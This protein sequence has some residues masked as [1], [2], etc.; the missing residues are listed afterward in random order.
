M[1]QQRESAYIRFPTIHEDRVVFSAEDDLWLVSAEGGVARRLTAGL[2]RSI[3]P[4]FTPDGQSL[5]FVGHEE[6]ERD[7]Y[8]MPAD[9]GPAARMTFTGGAVALAGFDRD[10]TPIAALNAKGPF[11][12]LAWLCRVPLDGGPVEDL[13][14]GPGLAVAFGPEGGMVLGR[15]TQDMG[16]RGA[17][18]PTPKR[19]RGG[20][21]GEL[22]IDA[23]GRG[24]FRPY[25][26]PE[27]GNLTAPMWIG[28]RIYFLSDCEGVGNLYSIRPDGSDLTRHT[29]HEGYYAR[30]ARTDGRRVVYH[31]GGS[32]YLC[33][34]AEDATRQ[35]PVELKSQRTQR[36]RRFV[37]PAEFLTEYAVHPTAE[38]L[39]VTTRGQLMALGPFE[40]PVVA[41][42]AESGVRTRLARWLTADRVVYC[43]DA[44]GEDRIVVASAVGPAAPEVLWADNIGEPTGLEANRGG[45][46]IAYTNHRLELWLL[47]V[48]TRRATLVEQ[49]GYGGPSGLAWSPDGRYLAYASPEGATRVAIRVLDSQDG[50]IHTVTNPVHADVAP[51]WDPA[52]RY[53]Y[54]LGERFLDPVYDQ[55]TFDLG[56]P[57]AM[58]P[59]LVTLTADEPS[60]FVGAPPKKAA[61][62]K[63][64]DAEP[65]PI[66]IDF[67]GIEDRVVPFPVEEGQYRQVLA[68]ADKV[69][70]T[71][72][73]AE[74][75]LS[76]SRGPQDAGGQ[77]TLLA[78]DLTARDT[79]TVAQKVTSA[80]LSASGRHLVYQSGKRLRW[81]NP[82]E[83]LPEGDS[84]GRKDGYLDWARVPVMVEPA[85]EWAQ[86]LRESYRMM[87]YRFWASD[88]SQVDWDQMYQRYADLLPRITTRD[89]FSDLVWEMQG[90]LGTLHTY[91]S[92]GD[93]RPAP[94][95]QP[96][97][98]GADF[99]WDAEAAG[100]RIT[101]IVHGDP[102][103]AGHDSP[104]RAPGVKVAEGDVLVAIDGRRTSAE[105]SPEYLLM[106]RQSQEVAL[107]VARPGAGERTVVVKTLASEELARY[108]EWVER[109]RAAV[110]RESG[111]RVGYLH[112]PDM[113]PWGFSEFF[114]LHAAEVHREALIVDVRFNRGGHVSPLLL[115]KV[116]RRPI[117]YAVPR[118]GVPRTYPGDAAT[119]PVVALTNDFAG[120]D[121]DIFSHNFKLMG[122]GKLVGMR[123][124]GGVIGINP[125]YRL[126]DN[127][128]VTQ[129]T[130]AFWF[131]DV[132]WGVEN[133]GTDP[134]IEVEYP[135]EA[136]RA[137]TDP[138][139]DRAI[140]EALAELA[141]HP[142][143]RPP[144]DP[145]PS[146]AAPSLP[147]R[148]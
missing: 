37:G 98:L 102:A 140:Q 16:A 57:R 67:D 27:Q 104:L 114:R 142:A 113:G 40:G 32:L 84:T 49:N 8:R 76:R 130:V 12:R 120:S 116:A 46:Q 112:I 129:P 1:S 111:G 99:S 33:D 39:L 135:P 110:H 15:K 30:N 66:R 103:V 134:D 34:P 75:A 29:D 92:G 127:T 25:R 137:G 95:F 69:L 90:E 147:P 107:T 7:L 123:T 125:R 121:G 72:F 143:E 48:A 97:Y 132:G 68:L 79:T 85:D 60:P 70:W 58:H 65:R 136:Y 124:W 144:E 20:T 14:W 62:E 74:G 28:G 133:H 115:E 87:R 100:W 64:A 63:D 41:V 109:N 148:H 11:A 19:Y 78:Y 89:E 56:F 80:S 42:Q 126:V 55:V 105:K 61:A 51:A 86:M 43:D 91:E 83:K 71:L 5:V 117:A 24:V 101:H 50:R 77:G 17:L 96:G 146:K 31:A 141:E 47:D 21:A 118:W 26:A 59:Y 18:S 82:A 9:G 44:G 139:L 122:L 54:F 35:I 81:V 4:R 131:K 94:K 3:E 119:G 36:A 22:W 108:R 53:L 38:R 13:N 52:G 128:S 145:R 6:G 10:G 106:R 88:M 2:G 73:P 93:H 45:T 138:Q 23:T